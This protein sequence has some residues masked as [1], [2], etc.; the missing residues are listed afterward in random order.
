MRLTRSTIV[1][2]LL[3][4]LAGALSCWWFRAIWRDT[5]L[6][7]VALS[8]LLFFGAG[9]LPSRPEWLRAILVGVFAGAFIAGCLAAGGF[10]THSAN[11][12]F[13]LMPTARLN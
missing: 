3:V 5:A 12:P 7:A 10:L 6:F 8:A 13:Q 11:Q 1:P 9:L 4:C 2:L